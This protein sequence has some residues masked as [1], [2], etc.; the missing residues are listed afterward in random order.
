MGFALHN[1]SEDGT[2]FVC[3]IFSDA[4]SWKAIESRIAEDPPRSS[5]PFLSESQ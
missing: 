4:G 5:Q 1:N 3:I 2:M